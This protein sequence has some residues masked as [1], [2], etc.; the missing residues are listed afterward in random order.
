[1]ADTIWEYLQSVEDIAKEC[2]DE[3]PDP[4]D[5]D[6]D[7][8]ISESVDGSYWIIYYS[9]NEIVL[10]ASENEPD[11]EEVAEL[12]GDGADW[13]RLRMIAAYS[14]MEAD[15]RES[16]AALDAEAVEVTA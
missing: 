5:D 16:V 1:M 11:G 8:Y 4:N 12:A 3:Y 14:A 13:R 10:E 15:V 7:T 2:R 6:R 9:A